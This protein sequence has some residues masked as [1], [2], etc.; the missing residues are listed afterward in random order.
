MP[1]NSFEYLRNLHFRNDILEYAITFQYDIFKSLGHFSDRKRFTP[2]IFTG[3]SIFHHNP[4]AKTPNDL[5][6]IWINLQPLGTEGQGREGFDKKY[7]LVGLNI[8]VGLGFNYKLARRW[9]VSLEFAYHLTNTDY[10]DDVSKSYIENSQFENNQLAAKMADRSLET[11]DILSG[12][13][14]EFF[15]TEPFSAGTKRATKGGNDSWLNVSLGVKFLLANTKNQKELSRIY[16][17]SDPV[18]PNPF[19]ALPKNNIPKKYRVHE[20]R[21]QITN[22][23]INTPDAEMYPSYYRGGIIYVSDKHGRKNY[24]KGGRNH[25]SNF[26]Y[27]P[28][29]DVMNN[30]LN[31]I[32]KINDRLY[33]NYHHGG[34]CYIV[35][36]DDLVLE[37]YQDNKAS[38]DKKPHKLFLARTT[39]ED[40]I[41]D[42]KPLPFNNA[43]YSVAHPAMD[44]SET[45][46]VFSSDMPGGY[47]GTDLYVSYNINGQWTYPVN[48][49][50]KIN[51]KGD[52]LFPYF[53][54][55]STLYFASNGHQGLG[56]L[57]IFEVIYSPDRADIDSL[58]NVG[59]P[60]NSE[61]DD[62][63]LI[64]DDVKRTGFFCS[65]RAGGKGSFDLYKLD[66]IKISTSRRLTAEGEDMIGK[67]EL[68]LKGFVVNKDTKKRLP[69]AI[70]RLRN[71]LED[72]FTIVKADSLGQFEFTI[73]NDAIYEIGSSALGFEPMEDR[74]ISTVDIS[75]PEEIESVLDLYPIRY[76]LS[77]HGKIRDEKSG[78]PIPNAKVSLIY[79]DD[80][81]Q[82]E[83]YANEQGEYDI[84]L[85]KGKKYKIII[86]K[87]GY[88]SKEY[89]LVTTTKKRSNE[90][91]VFFTELTT[92]SAE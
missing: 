3:I 41:E 53:H 31:K 61:A 27:S 71:V 33:H 89:D 21:F 56:G 26:F 36:T 63:G 39:A 8:P 20:E 76:I 83:Y 59:Y 52:E 32:V 74:L 22:L 68:K 90:K 78:L 72:D 58:A 17:I 66:V 55:D 28:L 34:V 43:E 11:I 81:D 25:F 85:V 47:G 1:V 15:N 91:T 2:Y 30:K 38:E 84:E 86:S 88:L 60:I 35:G 75:E 73:H 51:T 10:L 40:I 79:V 54:S 45:T 14:R 82:E 5:G 6:G 13:P 87:D 29:H 9:D 23:G 80:K 65:N 16:R 37:I 42:L 50:N 64:L 77:I 18:N 67:V 46:I 48:L 70:V 49:G 7:S 24:V 69:K 4:K 62:F 19:V 57:D 12:N 92:S 44:I